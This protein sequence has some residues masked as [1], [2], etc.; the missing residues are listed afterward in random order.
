MNSHVFT[1]ERGVILH[2]VRKL[3]KSLLRDQEE[4]QHLLRASEVML[5]AEEPSIRTVGLRVFC[6]FCILFY[7][8]I[9]YAYAP[10]CFYHE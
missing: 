6:F 3:W 1:E 9:L 5:N 7:S 4:Y 2:P 8:S 10:L